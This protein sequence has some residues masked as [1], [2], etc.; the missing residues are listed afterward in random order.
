MQNM[1]GLI[2][3]CV[4]I[5]MLMVYGVGH[6]QWKECRRRKAFEADAIRDRQELREK[7]DAAASD[8]AACAAVID[9]M[10]NHH[11]QRRRLHA[12]RNEQT[13]VSTWTM[14]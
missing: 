11:P 13:G 4:V 5:T 6:W 8:A 14:E 1:H 10:E 9:R 3:F 7:A 2:M 12:V